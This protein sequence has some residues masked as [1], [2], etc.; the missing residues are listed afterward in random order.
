MQEGII[1]LLKKKKKLYA[2]YTKLKPHLQLDYFVDWKQYGEDI[3]N[4][5]RNYKYTLTRA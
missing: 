5:N 3:V 4:E 1:F 2:I